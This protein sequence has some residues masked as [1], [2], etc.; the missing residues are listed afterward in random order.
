MS[1]DN[2]TDLFLASVKLEL[3]ILTKNCLKFTKYL[4]INEENWLEIYRF[5]LGEK[6]DGLLQV[7]FDFMRGKSADLIN[8]NGFQTLSF[9]EVCIICNFFILL[10]KNWASEFCRVIGFDFSVGFYAIH[11]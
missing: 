9:T 10:I 2:F 3:K 6:D 8:L 5:A 11:G 4:V 7:V 1:E